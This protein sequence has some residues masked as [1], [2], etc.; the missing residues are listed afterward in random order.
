MQGFW[1]FF[2]IQAVL[3]AVVLSVHTYIGLHIIRRNLIFSDLAL[4]QLAALGVII[5][6]G[7]GIEGGSSALYWVS[8]IAVIVGA[9]LLAVL[10]PRS[11]AIPREA[12]IGII[13]C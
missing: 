12:V 2:M 13:Y 3:V 5:G 9:V 6:I 4:D 1:S 7:L 10:K 8:L 11:D